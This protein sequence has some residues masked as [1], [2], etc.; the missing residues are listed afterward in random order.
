[1]LVVDHDPK[2]TSE[3]FL[4]FVK[5]MGS[6]LI[7]SSAYHTNTNAKVKHANCITCNTLLA[8]ANA[9]E[10]NWERQPTAPHCVRRQ[11]R[12][13]NS[14]RLAHTFFIDWGAR[15]RLPLFAQPSCCS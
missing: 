9:H 5:G 6:T 2:F 4:A 15:L 1:M 3:M 10:D 14:R 8:F 12:G 13:L 11:Q 7:V